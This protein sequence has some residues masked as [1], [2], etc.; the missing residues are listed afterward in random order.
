MCDAYGWDDPS[1]V[2]DEI[3]QS[4]QRARNNHAARQRPKAVA[5]F[6]EMIAWMH[7]H[8]PALKAAL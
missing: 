6:D 2:I 5:V 3:A 8:A 7:R 1:A 4:F